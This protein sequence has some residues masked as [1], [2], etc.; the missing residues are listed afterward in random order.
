[1][2]TGLH[3]DKTVLLHQGQG[4]ETFTQFFTFTAFL[5]AHTR[6]ST[7]HH[8]VRLHQTTFCKKYGLLIIAV[9]SL[10]IWIYLM[11]SGMEFQSKYKFLVFFWLPYLR[12][13]FPAHVPVEVHDLRTKRAVKIATSF[14]INMNATYTKGKNTILTMIVWEEMLFT[15]IL[16]T[17]VLW[18]LNKFLLLVR[19]NFFSTWTQNY[20]QS[21]QINCLKNIFWG[22][23]HWLVMISKYAKGLPEL[24]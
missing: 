10:T 1:M 12:T 6:K 7:M 22:W 23:N 21:R 17:K 2:S 20:L 11:C 13:H 9:Q 4:S 18:P 14:K 5:A 16:T 15:S 19:N 3:A 24:G 8:L